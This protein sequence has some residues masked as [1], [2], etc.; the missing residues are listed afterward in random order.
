ME[1]AGDEEDAGKAVDVNVLS[2]TPKIEEA[3]KVAKN[4]LNVHT[5]CISMKQLDLS[6][7]MPTDYKA[8]YEDKVKELQEVQ[9]FL[10][11]EEVTKLQVVLDQLQAENEEMKMKLS[12]F[13]SETAQIDSLRLCMKE[14]D[15]EMEKMTRSVATMQSRLAGT[16]MQFEQYKQNQE[17]RVKELLERLTE[18]GADE[19]QNLKKSLATIEEQKKTLEVCLEEQKKTREEE[20]KNNEN[21]INNLKEE[22]SHGEKIKHEIEHSLREKIKELEQSNKNLE[23]VSHLE[24][25]MN[26]LRETILILEKTIITLETEKQELSVR[27]N[28]TINV[29]VDQ[30][31][32]MNETHVPENNLS[33]LEM[34]NTL[35]CELI[36]KNLPETYQ[37]QIKTLE[38][39]IENLNKEKKLLIDEN[40]QLSTKLI[41][42]VEDNDNQRFKYERLL[43]E[44]NTKILGLREALRQLKT[45]N[46]T[47]QEQLKDM[48][49]YVTVLQTDKDTLND[50]V[51]SL[52]EE[53]G[54]QK[55]EMD[56]KIEFYVDK[57]TRC[58]E[59]VMELNSSISNL[60]LK[61]ED[62]E[63]QV[64]IAQS[65]ATNTIDINSDFK[66]LSDNYSALMKEDSLN[67]IMIS[68]MEAR[69]EKDK[70]QISALLNDIESQNEKMS[71][72][73]KIMQEKEDKIIV[74]NQ[75][76]SALEEKCRAKPE[77]NK[78]HM[79]E[80]EKTHKQQLMKLE[81][82]KKSLESEI[83]IMKNNIESIEKGFSDRI[84]VYQQRNS[85]WQQMFKKNNEKLDELV[86]DNTKMK[87]ILSQSRENVKNIW[88]LRQQIS[89]F[90]T[91]YNELVTERRQL[92]YSL[93]ASEKYC[94]QL[95]K[96]K[97]DLLLN[98]EQSKEEFSLIHRTKLDGQDAQLE[99][100]H[101]ELQE[102][103]DELDSVKLCVYRLQ[104]EEQDTMKS[105][106]EMRDQHLYQVNEL[107]GKIS[108]EEEEK[109]QLQMEKDQ[110]N[111]VNKELSRVITDLRALLEDLNVK[112]AKK[113]DTINSAKKSQ[114]QIEEELDSL[115]EQH[116]QEMEK[117]KTDLTQMD[118]L[119]EMVAKKKEA[120]NQLSYTNKN[121][122]SK[123][124]E[125]EPR[126]EYNLT[127]LESLRERVSH[128][129]SVQDELTKEKAILQNELY[130]K[131]S[132]VN[133]MTGKLRT[134]N[135]LKEE[136]QKMR[137]QNDNLN[138]E[139]KTV[140]DAAEVKQD[141]IKNLTRVLQENNRKI[142]D[143]Q[144]DLEMA[145]EEVEKPVSTEK[146]EILEKQNQEFIQQLKTM[147]T[148][149]EKKLK[150]FRV[151]NT[152]LVEDC[153]HL[154][155]K[156]SVI[157]EKEK[158]IELLK[159]RVKKK[160]KNIE[161][162]NTVVKEK[163]MEIN[164]LKTK[165]GDLRVGRDSSPTDRGNVQKERRR[166][167]RQS[168]YDH[169]R[170]ISFEI[171]H[172]VGTMTDPTSEQCQCGELAKKIQKLQLDLTRSQSLLFSAKK[173][174]EV[175]P[176][177][178]D[179]IMLEMEVSNKDQ[180]IRN[181]LNEIS[182]LQQAQFDRRDNGTGAYRKTPSTN[183]VSC[184]T[185]DCRAMKTQQFED[186]KAQK[187]NE[188]QNCNT[189]DYKN[190]FETLFSKYS[191]LKR[192]YFKM[193]ATYE[194]S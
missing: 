95:K 137:V 20:M 49:A 181:M 24:S 134:H 145:Q 62:L 143:L 158:E 77:M 157:G 101:R 111:C 109:R 1:S 122:Q 68:D 73:Y 174:L 124:N 132:E 144:R 97:T 86:R 125:L 67:R 118:L 87:A 46:Q 189:V 78:T 26:K 70:V 120:I 115:R 168:L 133:S 148:D 147:R 179:V 30:E 185:D 43:T 13:S 173:D 15:G 8:L 164:E 107:K 142:A 188:A 105:I 167:D 165:R 88:E 156:V 193:R 37:T 130:E 22:I 139:L 128:L 76:I 84:A 102:R 66:E 59:K 163:L 108:E 153:D 126:A 94:E 10:I 114:K 29:G 106:E 32:S 113:D 47:L 192:A 96:D 155:A 44:E 16:E 42:N 34:D 89:E 117:H 36:S 121:L 71:S 184:Q 23:K 79:G 60:V 35:V 98:F 140:R 161:K 25:E 154:K 123:V 69:Q 45:D 129:C 63:R 151:A 180:Q 2:E 182:R 21:L 55:A 110:L 17:G 31:I 116:R 56:K 82:E 38:S 162:L 135:N 170:S 48:E 85:E 50:K 81:D 160:D 103:N 54:I 40:E 33:L 172:D 149:Y 186:L 169:N 9:D 28:E 74:L 176:L 99:K 12:E 166:S 41:E 191:N 119:K 92:K 194:Q 39:T 171:E 53:W 65:Q 104:C 51:S 93:D 11:V 61:N 100:L 190:E 7:E 3:Q 138:T 72:D 146:L 177:K 6:G 19:V 5:P 58:E 131:T 75:R 183:Q 4:L 187:E 136:M 14:K 178:N 91:K 175:N 150:N 159:D 90:N 83:V 64:E 27:I 18:T 152:N 141:E 52:K 112:L 80:I 57:A 127:E